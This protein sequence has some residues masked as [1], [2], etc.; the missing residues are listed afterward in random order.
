ML[1]ALAL[2]AIVPSAH[3][4]VQLNAGDV[5]TYEFAIQPT[6]TS[7]N[8]DVTGIQ[9]TPTFSAFG[10]GDSIRI[11]LFE[12]SLAD[13]PWA[14]FG[15]NPQAPNPAGSS[16]NWIFDLQGV[17]QISV[18]SGSATLES[19]RFQGQRPAG[20]GAMERIDV[21]IVPVP[22]PGT[23][24]LLGLAGLGALGWRCRRPRA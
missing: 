11:D 5:F 18:Q 7:P 6:S 12:N 22:E 2:T 9:W 24:S 15:Y 1:A 19:M 8:F 13:T 20:G 14:S 17:I 23:W 4:Q 3:S 10:L 21:T 16:V